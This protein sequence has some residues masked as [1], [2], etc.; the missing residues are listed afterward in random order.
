M[1]PAAYDENT[2][3]WITDK[4][5]ADLQLALIEDELARCDHR[6]EM[7]RRGLIECTVCGSQHQTSRG[8]NANRKD[9]MD[10]WPK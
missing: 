1:R 8:T 10:W 7:V 5:K 9:P 2:R 3:F 6:Y 4:G